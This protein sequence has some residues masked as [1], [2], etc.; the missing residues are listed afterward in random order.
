[1][2]RV[3]KMKCL[4][5]LKN[6]P[7]FVFDKEVHGKYA[8]QSAPISK[9]WNTSKLGFHLEILEAKSYSYPYHFHHH[10]EEL[11]IVLSGSAMV[12]QEKEIFE[13]TEGDLIVFK[14]GIAHQF[15]NHTDQ[16]FKFFALSNNSPDEICEYPDSNKKWE[17]KEKR[18]TQNEMVIEDYFKDEENP[19]CFWPKMK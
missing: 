11:F 17:R 2:E 3:R 19:D 9:I 12:R 13:V 7:Q 15:Y 6:D 10:E 14:T 1:M 5:N 8:S 16:S 4:V 18:L